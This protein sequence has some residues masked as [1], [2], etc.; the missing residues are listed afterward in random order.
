MASR[1]SR[2]SSLY[3][4]LSVITTTYEGVIISCALMSSRVDVKSE[5]LFVSSVFRRTKN[6]TG[7]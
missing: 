2:V 7:G 5:M 3:S 1:V 6:P 4:T